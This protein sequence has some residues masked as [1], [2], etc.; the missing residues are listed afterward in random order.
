MEEKKRKQPM[1]SVIMGVYN[2]ENTVSGAIESVLTQTYQDFEFVIC[3]DGSS[4]STHDIVAEYAKKN[5]DQIV[6]IE[7]DRNR[8]LNYTLN[9]CLRYASGRFIARMDGDDL[10]MPERFEKEI[11]YFEKHPEIAILG[12]SLRVF[13]DEGA[14]GTHTF[15]E[16]PQ[17]LDFIH[18]TPFSHS[19]CM[20]R[21]EAYDAVGGYS[22]SVS[23]LRVED[24]HLWTKMYGKGF[25]G[26]NLSE[27]LY[28]YRDDRVGY[29]K[30]KYK[31]RLNEAY[32][33]SVAIKTLRLP[34]WCYVYALKPLFVG[35]LP[36]QIYNLLHKKKMN[37]RRS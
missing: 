13:D 2:C 37:V 18:G 23:L 17:P 31:Y 32:V 3:D 6:F 12:A 34:L 30:R 9:R 22:E 15:K 21:K 11:S 8:G 14:W 10:S 27:E 28:L 5:P 25:R 35:L 19:V 36:Y 4:D 24:Y 7:N 20:V 26:A 1:I 16:F 29:Q 33:T